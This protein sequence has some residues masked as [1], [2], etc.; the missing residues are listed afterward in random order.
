M[1]RGSW[2]NVGAVRPLVCGTRVRT[3]LKGGSL[4][5]RGHIVLLRRKDDARLLVD[6]VL[7]GST[8]RVTYNTVSN[9]R[10]RLPGFVYLG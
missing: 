2:V 1:P 4:L 9:I 6:I 7:V 5:D 3:G 10:L 8:S